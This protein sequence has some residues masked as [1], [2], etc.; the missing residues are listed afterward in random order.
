MTLG[1]SLI[2]FSIKVRSC[3]N[4][5]CWYHVTQYN[6]THVTERSNKQHQRTHIALR[7]DMEDPTLYLN[8][9]LGHGIFWIFLYSMWHWI[10]DLVAINVIANHNLSLNFATSSLLLTHVTILFV[11]I[12]IYLFHIN[13]YSMNWATSNPLYL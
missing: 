4:P 13:T 12:L 2:H 6:L 10:V 1:K 3:I 7:N 8:T 5:Y 9:L 11:I